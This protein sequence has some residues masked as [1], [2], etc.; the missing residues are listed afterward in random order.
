MWKSALIVG[1]AAVV[2]LAPSPAAADFGTPRQGFGLGIGMGTGATGLSGKL[3]MGAGRHPGRRRCLGR[4]GRRRPAAGR[5]VP[6]LDGVALSVDYLFEMPTLA[7]SEYFNL[8]WCFGLGGGVG[9]STGGGTPGVAVAGIAGLEFN[10][11][12]APIDVA[13]EYRPVGRASAR[14]VQAGDRIH[15][16]RAPLVLNAGR[17]ETSQSIAAAT[18]ARARAR[19][20][21][22]LA[23]IVRARDPAAARTELTNAAREAGPTPALTMAAIAMARTLPPPER[24][25]WLGG[26]ARTG[27]GTAVP[28]IAAALAG[29]QLDADQ[30]R[31]AAMHAARAGA[32]RTLAAAPPARGGATRRCAWAIASRRRWRARCRVYTARGL[33]RE[34]RGARCCGA[35]WRCRATSEAIRH[36]RGRRGA[37]AH[38][39]EWLKWAARRR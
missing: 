30:P 37:R 24:V 33:A 8:D 21:V 34:R 11:I 18:D 13:I 35:R 19:L 23:G 20:R 1:F 12:K 5:G 7:K 27:E 16:A 38:L 15:G 32:R 2:L 39:L 3:M 36:R 9:V 29:A 28:G 25:V 17:E 6:Q 4:Q 22:E 26:L 14:A 10:F 31:D